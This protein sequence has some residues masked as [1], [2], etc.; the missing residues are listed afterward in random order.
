MCGYF[1]ANFHHYI[2]D[3]PEKICNGAPNQLQTFPIVR[4]RADISSGLENWTLL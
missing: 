3:L 2:A 1:A 4:P